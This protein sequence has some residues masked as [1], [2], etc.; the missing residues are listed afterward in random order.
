[1]RLPAGCVVVRGSIRSTEILRSASC[2][3]LLRLWL[4]PFHGDSSFGFLRG[5]SFLSFSQ[6]FPRRF[7]LCVLTGSFLALQDFPE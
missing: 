1:M 5:A 7:F 3:V 6:S 2:G 4:H